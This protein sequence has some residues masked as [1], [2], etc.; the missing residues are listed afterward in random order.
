MMEFATA[1]PT[2]ANGGLRVE[3]TCITRIED[4][5]GI[6]LYQYHPTP[7]RVADPNRVYDLVTMMKGVV[8]YGTGKAAK[9][10]RPVAGK[11]GTTSD[12]RDAWFVGFVPQLVCATWVGNDNNSPMK[13]VT[14]GSL[15]AILW[16]EMMKYALEDVPPKDFQPPKWGLALPPVLT[17]ATENF[18]SSEDA[19][20]ISELPQNI[21]PSEDETLTPNAEIQSQP[22]FFSTR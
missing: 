21:P 3:P 13:K 7:K 8:D 19:V 18:R 14:G 4:R 9:L 16:R 10:P 20:Y 1:Y 22:D 12:Y 11:T 2:L 17:A 15:P 6:P 5:N